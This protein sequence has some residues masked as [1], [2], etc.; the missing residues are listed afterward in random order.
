MSAT[1]KENTNCYLN[2]QEA[3]VEN[4]FQHITGN[5]DRVKELERIDPRGKPLKRV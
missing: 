5:L 2:E 1:Q 3:E 4:P